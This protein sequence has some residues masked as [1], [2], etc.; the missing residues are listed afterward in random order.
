MPANFNAKTLK[1]HLLAQAAMGFNIHGLGDDVFCLIQH[2]LQQLLED[3]LEFGRLETYE[4]T[5][6]LM[7]FG[8]GLEDLE[9][10]LG[11]V[12]S[13]EWK[14]SIIA[15]ILKTRPEN[16]GQKLAAWQEQHGSN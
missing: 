14:H 11:P 8:F 13:P 12:A 15:Q 2:D 9:K 7:Q 16:L 10:S 3:I 4:R 5:L 6:E 1:A